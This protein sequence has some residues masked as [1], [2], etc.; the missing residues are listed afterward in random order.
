MHK[1][2]QSRI[3]KGR[4]A[5]RKAW[6]KSMRKSVRRM[7]R[8]RRS[9]MWSFRQRGNS[10]RS[11]RRSGG[12]WGRR[13]SRRQDLANLW[14]NTV[15]SISWRL[16]YKTDAS[17]TISVIAM[18]AVR[19][20]PKHAHKLCSSVQP[21]VWFKFNILCWLIVYIFSSNL[22]IWSHHSGFPIYGTVRFNFC[23]WCKM[24]REDLS[25]QKQLDPQALI[26]LAINLILFWVNL[27][28]Y[29][30]DS[31]NVPQLSL[32]GKYKSNTIIFRI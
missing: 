3:I 29:V 16:R 6:R 32:L 14:W 28:Q 22:W 27:I 25:A 26:P 8:L 13:C 9:G 17:D 15:S 24:I 2:C 5:L 1:M 11:L 4:S 18:T 30:S 10:R 31:A 20:G 12:N 23:K 7:R 21:S 19:P